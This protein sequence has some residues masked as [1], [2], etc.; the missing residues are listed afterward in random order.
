[1]AIR[2]ALGEDSMLVREGLRQVLAQQ[3]QIDV[4]AACEDMPSLLAAIES[5]RPDVVLTDIR[6]P[7][8]NTDEGIQV[9]TR[10]RQ[11]RPEVGVIVLSQYADPVYA[12][13]LLQDSSDGRGYRRKERLHDPEQLRTAIE[14]VA[15]GGSV[16][17]PKVVEALVDERSRTD[18]S[19]LAELTARELEV[20]DQI[21]QGK[22]NAAIASSL[23]L[24]KRAVEKH[25]NSIFTKLKLTDSEDVSKR[26]KAALL[27][28]VDAAEQR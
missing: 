5:E 18:R 27:F 7:P 9:A 6:M 8:S 28:L 10:L 24:T 15:A 4:V 20:L 1:V 11:T 17:D 23:F 22:S 12:L 26:V 25:I 13:S 19:P 16:I 21:A 14:T 2:V 3:P